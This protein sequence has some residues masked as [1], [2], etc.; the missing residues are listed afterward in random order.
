MPPL[1]RF[2][3]VIVATLVALGRYLQEARRLSIIKRLP[4]R[5]ARDYYE[6]TRQ[7]NERFLL[8]LASLLVALAIGA[9]IYTFV[10]PR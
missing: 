4:G 5:E 6:R 7:N 3:L 9:V 1:F 8:V 2:A 10:L